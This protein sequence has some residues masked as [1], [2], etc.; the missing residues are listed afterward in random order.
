MIFR[1]DTDAVRAMAAKFRSTA[2]TM[3][4]SLTAI[5]QGVKGAP[6]QSQ[7]REEFI[8]LLETL[9][10]GTLRSAEVLRMMAGAAEEKASQWEAIANI[11][12][13]P[14]QAL[15]G[16][17][18]Q[19]KDNMGWLWGRIKGAITGVRLPSVP[20]VVLP[21]VTFGGII[22]WFD[23]IVPDWS[24][25]KLTWWPPKKS[26]SSTGTKEKADEDR[27]QG[28]KEKGKADS[29]TKEEK[30]QPA[31]SD[32]KEHYNKQYDGSSPAR[33]TEKKPWV[34]INA[35]L[36]NSPGNRDPD[37]YSDVLDQFAVESNSRYTKN[38]QGK[39]ET[40]C[41]IFVWDATKA[42]GAEIPH[43]VDS[44]GN[45]VPQGQGSELSAN[46]TIGWLETHGVEQGWKV[47]TAEEAQ[48]MANQGKPVVASWENPTGI[49]HVAMVRPGEYS[50][51]T[52]PHLA[53]AGANN[54]NHTTVSE[55]F[56][57]KEVIYYYHD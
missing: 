43:W 26:G 7:A 51:A 5:N 36:Q 21:V 54:Y 53:Q 47:L 38:Q 11:F 17:W 57:N 31:S 19:L 13:G 55:T 39:D 8:T 28:E 9:Q 29:S 46:G 12:N 34:D 24:W 45:P 16:L 50:S 48:A 52:G 56:R 20:H 2:N 25:K 33:G 40:Y 23:R 32:Q 22:G 10:G 18:N 35:P 41:N 14:F 42:M 27:D 44:K 49:G 30:E 3:E 15:S 1:M 37:S 6:W 4:T